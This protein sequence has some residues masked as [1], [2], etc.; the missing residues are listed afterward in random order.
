MAY[1]GFIA[2]TDLR[3]V[4]GVKPLFRLIICIFNLLSYLLRYII[5][6]WPSP[7]PPQPIA[8]LK[9]TTVMLY[10]EYC[11]LRSNFTSQSVFR[12]FNREQ[13]LLLL[14]L[15]LFLILLLGQK[16]SGK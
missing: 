4:Q 1:Y 8:D 7:S 16:A 9:T 12:M 11:F 15:L 5:Y 3:W 14:L 13:I 2:Q 10:N 6:K